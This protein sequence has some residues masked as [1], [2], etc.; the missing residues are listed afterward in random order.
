MADGARIHFPSGHSEIA[1]I[2]QAPRVGEELL[3]ERPSLCSRRKP[4]AAASVRCLD[5]GPYTLRCI[6]PRSFERRPH[7]RAPKW[8]EPKARTRVGMSDPRQEMPQWRPAR[9]SICRRRRR[10]TRTGQPPTAPSHP[11]RACTRRHPRPA[12]AT[13][14]GVDPELVDVEKRSSDTLELLACGEVALAGDRKPMTPL[15]RNTWE[16]NAAHVSAHRARA[17][18]ECET[19]ARQLRAVARKFGK[20]PH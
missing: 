4:G 10:S 20:Y 2:T 5:S 15:D 19:R 14:Q 1:V 17:V 12:D 9:S 6:R 11:S 7:R 13:W 18:R 16:G 3:G 8:L